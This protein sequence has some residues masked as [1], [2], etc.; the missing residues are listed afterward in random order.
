VNN[1]KNVYKSPP[2]Y[3][4]GGEHSRE[5][6]NEKDWCRQLCDKK[7]SLLYFEGFSYICLLPQI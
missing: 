7:K 4:S 1:E 6:D 2:I 3:G 5:P